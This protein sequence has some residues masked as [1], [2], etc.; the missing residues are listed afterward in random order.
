MIYKLRH[1]DIFDP[2][3][4]NKI[5]SE[6]KKRNKRKQQQQKQ[7]NKQTNKPQITEG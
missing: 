1:L 3:P 4:S 7:T 5:Q 6:K 2:F